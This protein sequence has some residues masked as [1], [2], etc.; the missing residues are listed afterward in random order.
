MQAKTSSFKYK[1][2]GSGATRSLS[3][4]DGGLGCTETPQETLQSG[5]PQG[6]D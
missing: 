3:L 5:P 6:K 4:K 1:C 2:S